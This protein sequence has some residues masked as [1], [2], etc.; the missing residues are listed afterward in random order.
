MFPWRNNTVKTTQSI[1][2]FLFVSSKPYRK[3]PDIAD[4]P[5]YISG[6]AG[7]ICITC[8]RKI[9]M[10]N[11]D[12]GSTCSLMDPLLWEPG[13]SWESRRNGSATTNPGVTWGTHSASLDEGLEQRR[14]TAWAETG[15]FCWPF[16]L[17]LRWELQ[18]PAFIYSDKNNWISSTQIKGHRWL[19]W[20]ERKGQRHQLQLQ[21]PPRIS[22]ML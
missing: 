22:R 17:S 4:L 15:N 11:W 19:L 5:S 18:Q 2:L 9:S 13:D 20:T 3:H 10:C 8:K 21:S 6:R 7:Y 16:A 1:S 14:G 12:L